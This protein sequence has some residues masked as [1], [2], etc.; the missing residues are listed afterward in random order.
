MP[1]RFDGPEPT[2]YDF[3]VLTEI[4]EE[5]YAGVRSTY[6]ILVELLQDLP[7]EKKLAFSIV[8]THLQEAKMALEI[9]SKELYDIN[10]S[11]NN[12]IDYKWEADDDNKE[13]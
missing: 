3:T 4:L 5:D 8:H 7:P 10:F 2:N 13:S 12:H 9:A 1:F 6:D 11:L